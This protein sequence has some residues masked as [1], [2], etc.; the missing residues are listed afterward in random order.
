MDKLLKEF[1]HGIK[2][3]AR[4]SHKKITLYYLLAA[5]ESEVDFLTLDEALDKEALIIPVAASGPSAIP[6]KGIRPRYPVR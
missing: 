6:R 4:Q 1:F 2:V 3:G 5:T